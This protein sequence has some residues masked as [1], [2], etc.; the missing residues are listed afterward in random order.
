[1]LVSVRDEDEVAA[2]LAGGAD[3]I[4]AK[5]PARGALGPVSSAILRSIAARVPETIAMSA[6][7]G[8]F[9]S[10]DTV[11][12]AVNGVDI[13]QRSAA[14]YLKL[15]FAGQPS[16]AVVTS[17]IAAALGA[18]GAGRTIVPVAYADHERAGAP[19]PEAV[20]RATVA[21]GARAFLIDTYAK[22]GGGLLDCI[23][24][25]RLRTLSADGRSAGLLLAVAGSLTAD[26]LDRMAGLADVLGVRGAA[27]RGGREGRV[28]AD[29][30][31]R[32]RGRL[33]GTL[34]FSAG[35]S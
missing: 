10:P 5:E 29:L 1:L 4:D 34:P 9:T 12:R 7:L 20:L 35:V 31:R 13:S 21:A 17:L 26:T 22:D 14:T 8:D 11:R 2:T 32:L 30:V 27:C 33:Q 28:D 19:A 6:A 25:S 3:I 23:A 16:E 18:A 24:A 15:G